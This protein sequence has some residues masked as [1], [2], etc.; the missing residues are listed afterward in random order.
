[1]SSE[2]TVSVVIPTYNRPEMLAR[3]VESVTAQTYDEI[4][5]VVVDDHSPTP[6]AETLDALETKVLYSVECIRHEENRGGSAA[7][8]TGIEA[9][10]GDWIAFLDDDDEWKR[11]KLTKQIQRVE[12]ASSDVALVYTGIR[13][14]DER[15]S[16]IAMKTPTGEGD[17]L[18]HLLRGN[19]IGTYS[20][21]MVHS[22]A[23][24]AVGSPD[25][26][27]PSWQD[28]EWYLRLANYG[29]FASV[30]EPLAIRYNY[31]E[32]MSSDFEMKQDISY[33]LLLETGRPIAQELKSEFEAGAAFELA[34]A[35]VQ[36][37]RF[38][39]ARRYL[40]RSLRLESRSASTWLYLA[41]TIGGHY[42][43]RPAQRIKQTVVRYLGVSI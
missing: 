29:K 7:R 26:R 34:R 37:G 33:P 30:P 13:Q 14:V 36:N 39:A 23:V 16:T 2:P 35:A 1:M 43:F 22:D 9:A 28:W 3:A 41:L 11:T 21:V 42:T 19:F 4:E 15:G 32:Q 17:V 6:A 5:L 12:S 31:H 40:L 10:S 25:E 18:E 24:A 20:A 38:R 8:T 27:F